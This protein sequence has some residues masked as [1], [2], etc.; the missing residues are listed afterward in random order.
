MPVVIPKALP[1]NEALRKENIFVMNEKRAL[2][3][4]IRP[5]EILILN[6]MPTKEKTETQLIRLLSN[7]PLQINVTLLRTGSYRPKNVSKYHLDSFYKTFDEVCHKSYDGLIITGAPV[8]HL[9]FEAVEYWDELKRIFEFADQHITSSIYICWAAQASLY[10][11]YNLEKTDYK[12]KLSG[13]FEH[14][15]KAYN[16]K[17]LRGFDKIFKMPHS[18]YTNTSIGDELLVLAAS[19]EAG[20]SIVSTEDYKHIFI[21]GHFEYDEDTLDLE[22]KRDILNLELPR[23]PKNY[24]VD[25][26]PKKGIQMNWRSSAHLFFSNWLNYCVYQETPYIIE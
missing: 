9:A 20:Q 23:L 5:L 24:Y 18:R 1:A 21:S 10:Y 13:V 11:H 7:T 25:N 22:Y 14:R 2:H 17:L 16:S 4:D 12:T 6:L 26:D 19:D 8:E 3:Q 15:V